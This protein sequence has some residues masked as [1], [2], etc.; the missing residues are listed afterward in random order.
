MPLVMDLHITH[1]RFGSSSDP[2]INGHLHYPHDLDRTLNEDAANKTRQYLSDYYNR[3]SHVIVFMPT[4]ASTSGRLHCEFVC[5]LF[6]Q[7]HRETDRFL[8]TSG[9]HLAQSHFHFRRV[10]FSS[11]LKRKVGHILVKDAALRIMLN[12]DG[13]PIA[14]RSHTH[15]A[16]TQGPH[17]TQCM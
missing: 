17:S 8:S 6:L 3:P 10:V 11:H 7:A 4:I 14:S 2:S 15:P 12:V 16:H 9:V 13:A 5:L 1:E